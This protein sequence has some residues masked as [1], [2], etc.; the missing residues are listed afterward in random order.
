[1]PNIRARI[2]YLQKLKLYESEKPF[3]MLLAPQEGFDPDEKRLDNLEY[4]AH[5]NI[6]IR[7]IREAEDKLN[8]AE[9][10]F[11]VL[12]HTSNFLD[13]NSRES[14]EA[15]GRETEEL[16]KE[17]LGAVHVKCYEVRKRENVPMSRKQMDYYD[18]LLIEGPA[19]VSA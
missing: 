3:Y 10:G 16:L 6:L 2:D 14:V 19:K 18:P 12:S 13:L 17:Q 9:N 7:D 4:E 1:M 5:E 8:L 15:Y 11:Q